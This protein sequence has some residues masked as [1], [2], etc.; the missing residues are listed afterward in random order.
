MATVVKN[1]I[2]TLDFI[3]F[4]CIVAIRKCIEVS[5]RM[6]RTDMIVCT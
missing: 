2:P 5:L 1:A 4:T 6:F 3:K